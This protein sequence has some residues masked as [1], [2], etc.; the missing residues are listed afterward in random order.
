MKINNIGENEFVLRLVRQ[1]V[2]SVK[3]VWI[4]LGFNTEADQKTWIDNSHP[5][6]TCWSPGEPSGFEHQPCGEMF[7]DNTAE[8]P[9]NCY[10]NDLTFKKTNAIVC[11]KLADHG[12][13]IYNSHSKSELVPRN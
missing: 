6:F 4:G 9:V 10:W 1:E 12:S 13:Y 3:H 7:V 2:P 8:L 11:K 5:F